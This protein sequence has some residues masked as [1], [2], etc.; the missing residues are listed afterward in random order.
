LPKEA[1]DG[2]GHES[3]PITSAT[4]SEFNNGTRVGNPMLKNID[5]GGEAG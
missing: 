2:A 1:D 3:P 5:R 4:D